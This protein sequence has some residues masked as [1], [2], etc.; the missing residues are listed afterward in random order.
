MRK[1]VLCIKDVLEERR[2]IEEANEAMR[3]KLKEAF[4]NAG[5]EK[6]VDPVEEEAKNMVLYL[7]F[8]AH[9]L[10]RTQKIEGIFSLHGKKYG[11]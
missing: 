7:L 6:K 8:R 10:I 4:E 11:F 1:K 9:H 2:R 5:E 3:R